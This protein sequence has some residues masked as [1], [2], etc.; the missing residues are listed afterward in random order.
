MLSRTMVPVAVKRLLHCM[1]GAL[2]PAKCVGCGRLFHHNA[3]TPESINACIKAHATGFA[4]AMAPHFCPNCRGQW[5]PVKSPLCFRCGLVFK[6]REGEDHLCGRC[7]DRPGAFTRARAAGIYAD[8]LQTAIHALK[9]KGKVGLAGPLGRL[10][11]DTFQ[12]YWLPNEIDMVAPIPL[13][14]RRFR[15][16]GFNQAYLLVKR[17]TLPSETVIDR[18]LLVRTRATA[19]QTG[20]DRRQRRININN[21]F[22][23]NRPGQSAGK[24][25][26][27]VDDVLTTGATADACASALIRDGAK[28]VDV[29]TLARAL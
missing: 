25:V 2:F 19:P 20:L 22:L 29:L 1:G 16:R 15:Q 11:Y 24:R 27:L 3:G 21:A 13:H 4:H 6:S 17:W 9:F 10:L 23:A 26:L 7:L 18:D 28:R 8:A 12:Q 14:R 5:T